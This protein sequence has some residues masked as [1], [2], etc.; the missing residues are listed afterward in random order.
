MKTAPARGSHLPVLMMLITMTSGPV[1][2]L[3]CGMYSTPFLHW[4]CFTDNR[5]LITYENNPDYMEFANQFAK[6]SH[7]V[8]F[9]KDWRKLDLSGQCSIAF[10]D[11]APDRERYLE[12]ARLTHA[13]YVVAHDAENANRRKYHYEKVFHLYKYRSK[14][15]HAFPYTLVLSNVNDVRKIFT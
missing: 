9:V 13:E 14:Y 2:E 15:S 12:M 5:K 6:E 4:A 1:F 3:G 11:H 10:C 8:I 7:E